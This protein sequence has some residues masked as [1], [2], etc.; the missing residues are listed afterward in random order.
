MD[1]GH[2]LGLN[3]AGK[4]S[5]RLPAVN[6]TSPPL[7]TA[8]IGNGF[9]INPDKAHYAD[10]N[11]RRIVTGVK[12]NAGLNVD[13]R[14]IRRIRAILHSIETIGLASAQTR[15]AAG[16]G[17]G[18]LVAHLR[19]KIGYI[20]HLKGQ[21]DPVVRAVAQR[22]NRSFPLAP[23][24]LMPTP[25]ERRDRAVWVIDVPDQHNGTA[26]FLAG[27]GLV[28]AAHCV[29]DLGEVEVLHPSRHTTRFPA[30]VRHY[31]ERR[32][33]AVLDHSAIPATEF[34][35]LEPA[36]KPAAVGDPV[37]AVGY[38]LWGLAERLNI[39]RGEV[40]LLTAFFGVQKIEVTQQLTQGMS[41]GPILN[42][43]DQVVGIIQ[44]GGPDE[45]RQLAARLSELEASLKKQAR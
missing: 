3:L 32:D 25:E 38:P 9:A 15:Y 7:R 39:R 11:S 22:Y 1:G 27:V 29:K 33:L 19:G 17:K 28:T 41:G 31:D 5:S 34:Y 14:Y 43:A 8:I 2:R 42:I 4:G 24:K 20:A 16:G 26:F 23:I 6:L 12:I 36:P 18:P 13:R 44:T 45:G 30:K 10:R 21:T 35:E 37:L 40:S